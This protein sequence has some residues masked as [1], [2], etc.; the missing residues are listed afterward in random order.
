MAT[1]A[2]QLALMAQYT[3]SDGKVNSD[4][5][6]NLDS[7]QFLRDDV[8]ET[9]AG[10]LQFTGTGY[11][12][13]PSGTTAQRP[14][15]NG[16]TEANGAFH[17]ATRHNTDTGVLEQYISDNV[18][19]SIAPSVAVTEVTLP[20]SQTAVFTGDSIGVTGIAFD[21]GVVASFV[22]NNSNETNASSTTRNSS[23]SLT[24]VIPA[25]SEGTYSLKVLNQTGSS[26]ILENAVSVDGVA[27]F[28]SPA[29]SLGSIID[30]YDSANFDAGAT[31]DGSPVDV[32]ITSGSL[33]PG[34]SINSTGA[35]TGTSNTG[36]A[37]T[38]YSFTVSATDSENQTATRTFTI[39]V[40][41]NYQP[42]GSAT[43][44]GVTP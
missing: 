43:F 39:T 17:G 10:N 22:D 16:T 36:L 33:P 28:N 2:S 41:E 42:D 18:W 27:A 21:S 1:K 11:V 34:L 12:L 6:D 4:L 38:T 7:S 25:L 20:G 13:L 9:M 14:W 15:T 32:S 40:E 8:D 23:T 26:A 3:A 29:G 19:V 5:I 30:N 35:I 44:G 37:D 24:V 31:E